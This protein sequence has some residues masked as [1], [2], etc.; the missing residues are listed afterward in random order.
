ML[1][2]GDLGEDSEK[3]GSSYIPL[4]YDTSCLGSD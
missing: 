1:L 2:L 3:V 4:N